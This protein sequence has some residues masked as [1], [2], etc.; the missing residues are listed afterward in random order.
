LRRSPLA[1]PA[2]LLLSSYC[3]AGALEFV[4]AGVPVLFLVCFL[5]CFLA[6]GAGVE[7]WPFAGA[8]A[9]APKDRAAAKAVP[10]IKVVK[11]FIF[12]FSSLGVSLSPS[13]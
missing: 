7:D 5:A 6:A 10:N 11:R 1:E 13:I 8:G 9:W 12:V 4:E 2:G 3:L